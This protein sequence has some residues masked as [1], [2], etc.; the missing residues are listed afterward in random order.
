ML[1]VVIAIVWLIS[2]FV[3]KHDESF[4]ITAQLNEAEQDSVLV[5][6][7]KYSIIKIG[8]EVEKNQLIGYRKDEHELKSMQALNDAFSNYRDLDELN[9]NI[10]DIYINDV[11]I[12][13]L[14][15]D[16]LNNLKQTA[17]KYINELLEPTRK[18]FETDKKAK[19]LLE[20]VKS[21]QI[22]R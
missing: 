15:S 22:T 10:K 17:S 18:H 9:A 19:E 20:K 8:T 12:K 13:Q 16:L 3:V 7:L 1:F 11:E 4:N 14:Y 6:E 21:F 5:T 2:L